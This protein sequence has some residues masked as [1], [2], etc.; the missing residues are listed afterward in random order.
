M[1]QHADAGH[2]DHHAGRKSV[3]L[4][5]DVDGEVTNGRPWE[6]H[7]T[8]RL[9]QQQRDHKSGDRGGGRN[10]RNQPGL[11]QDELV[12][13]RDDERE[14]EEDPSEIH[15]MGSEEKSLTTDF[16]DLLIFKIDVGDSLDCQGGWFEIENQTD[17][18]FGD[19]E[20]AENLGD[21]DVD[22]LIDDF[23]FYDDF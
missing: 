15:E 22:D 10:D 23:G 13:R 17:F 19:A 12:H 14:E 6:R 7:H 18:E 16:T 21:V 4:D 2:H 9:E 5:A 1:D 3:Q 8:R 20:V 11:F